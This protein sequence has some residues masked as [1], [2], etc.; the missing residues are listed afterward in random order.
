MLKIFSCRRSSIALIGM[1]LLSALGAYLK[2][3]TSGSIAMIVM[4]IA[5]ANASEAAVGKFTKKD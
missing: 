1:V 2:V 5:A 3:D 4:G